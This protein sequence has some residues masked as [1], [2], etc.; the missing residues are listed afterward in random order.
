MCPLGKPGFSMCLFLRSKSDSWEGD[1]VMKS[2]ARL[3]GRPGLE[4]E[5]STKQYTINTP[6]G[7]V[8]KGTQ[9]TTKMGSTGDRQFGVVTKMS[10]R[11]GMSRSSSKKDPG[12]GGESWVKGR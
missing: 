9:A 1:I 7:L 3:G 10:V 5:V 6:S 8:R 4:L 12:R 11:Y 2:E